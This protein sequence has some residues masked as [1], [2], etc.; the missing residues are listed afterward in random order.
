MALANRLACRVG[1][2][3]IVLAALA[4]WLLF[5]AYAL[6]VH[7]KELDVDAVFPFA[8]VSILRLGILLGPVLALQL[9]AHYR[10]DMT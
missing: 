3:S 4:Y 7:G 8:L 9:V 10:L 2:R 6:L 1:A 5:S